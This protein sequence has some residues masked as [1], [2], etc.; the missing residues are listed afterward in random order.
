L[1]YLKLGKA[2]GLDNINPEILEVDLDT[3]P[4]VLLPLFEHIWETEKMPDDW[5]GGLLVK[6]PK[7]R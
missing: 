3:T 5:K 6:I 4:T 7:K 1:K 2:P